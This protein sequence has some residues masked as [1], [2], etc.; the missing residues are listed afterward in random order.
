[1]AQLPWDEMR[2]LGALLG[3]GL[4]LAPLLPLTPLSSPL[5][6]L[7]AARAG[8][9]SATA[10]TAAAAK[11]EEVVM[12]VPVRG[13]IA[14]ITGEGGNIG[15]LTGADG[16]FLIDDKFAPLTEKILVAL[17][18]VGGEAPR[19]VFNTHYHG[20][21][22]GGNENFAKGGATIV[23]HENVRRWLKQGTTVEAFEM[24]TPPAPAAALP[25]ITF[26]EEIRF[27]LNGETIDVIHLPAAHTDSDSLVAFRQA[28]V[29]HA[30]DAWFN[31]FY[32]FIDTAH[33]GTLKGAIA[34]VDTILRQADDDTLIIPGHGP[35]GKR[36]ELVEYRTM[37]A[38]ARQRL[39]A[40]KGRGLSEKE[41]VAAQPLKDLE[42]RWGKG[43]FSGDRWIKVIWEGV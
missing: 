24:I 35:L 38:I 12:A 41:A 37:L 23:S 20:D 1:M 5:Q 43:L 31:G 21:H 10:D 6:A 13:P 19:F 11:P 3:G 26:R 17:R 2:L 29:I 4:S 33:G 27:H 7:P 28:N 30:G 15:V 40:L 22:T 8:A 25:V 39:G 42:E 36:A 16:T 9:S 32:P 34:A 18:T 14:M